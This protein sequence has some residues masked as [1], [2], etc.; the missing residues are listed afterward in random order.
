MPTH[1]RPMLANII[2]S[3]VIFSF[4]F[5]LQSR[6]AFLGLDLHHDL[7]MFNSAV[8]FNQGLIP[9]SDFFYQYNLGTL[10]IHS[11]ALLLWGVKIVSL[12][13]I[14]V[15]SYALISVGIYL[16]CAIRGYQKVGVCVSLIWTS[17]SI[18]YMPEMNGYHPWSTL[19]MMASCMIGLIFLSMALTKKYVINSFLAGIF[20]GAAFWFKQVAALQVIAIYAWMLINLF[21]FN[22]VEG[23]QK[24]FLW[25]LLGFTLGLSLIQLPFI[26][27][28]YKSGAYYDWYLQ[29]YKFNKY[30]S[31]ESSSLGG[32]TNF[33][34]LLFPISAIS[35]YRNFIWA[36]C[37]I[38]LLII[39]ISFF[40]RK[41]KY[42]DLDDTFSYGLLF[43]ILS[44]VGWV[45]YFPL[46]HAFHA[47][48][49]LAP[50]FVYVGIISAI[51]PIKELKNF[52]N[53]MIFLAL[54]LFYSD[55]ILEVTRHLNGIRHKVAQHQT[56]NS[57]SWN[58]VMDGI[59]LRDDQFSSLLSFYEGLK[60]VGE[61]GKKNE[62][63]IPLSVDP[64]VTM[65]PPQDLPSKRNKMDVNWTW[66]NE[67]INPGFFSNIN[68]L[69]DKNTNDVYGDAPI[70]LKGYK[71]KN[72]LEMNSPLTNVHTL[73]VPV[74]NFIRLNDKFEESSNILF[75]NSY[76]FNV[77]SR[78]KFFD[79]NL[80][81]KPY[82][83]IPIDKSFVNYLSDIQNIHIL[84]LDNKNFARSI[85]AV[86][87][88]Y[89]NNYAA[90]KQIYTNDGEGTL[91]IKAELSTQD[92]Y[93][94]AFFMLSTG[95]LNQFEANKPQFF[96]TLQNRNESKPFI[97]YLPKGDFLFDILW[98]GG[99]PSKKIFKY[100][101]APFEKIYVGVPGGFIDKALDT[102][103]MVQIELKNGALINQ[104][105][106]FRK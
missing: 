93:N 89:I 43:L 20:I 50:F 69:L 15:I 83:L 72:I 27:F 14:T 40:W 9:Y 37:P 10:Y 7:L 67:L 60:S 19:Y 86:N 68:H 39:V 4:A 62:E 51:F 44:L 38:S 103:L 96:S 104:F 30:F 78:S 17:L 85:P 100:T 42:Q 105:Y 57:I 75:V 53:L 13:K 65:L 101:S 23:K 35:G 92:K 47:Q 32:L 54:L 58:S 25:I 71:L 76:D 26:L 61:I 84:K 59:K 33:V 88:M 41:K 49:F 82:N 29:A 102:Y 70:Y 56:S 95:K 1:S 80:D 91:R 81:R 97:T 90:L 2:M 34:K 55:S 45:E 21:I 106:I 36:V 66:A 94:L 73:Y 48:I 63:I 52:G 18:F 79:W 3:V 8:K 74:K 64:L 6:V 99:I 24:K 5:Y 87:E 16:S 11:I 22:G 46:P 31:Q 98:G 28:L 12:K 77:I